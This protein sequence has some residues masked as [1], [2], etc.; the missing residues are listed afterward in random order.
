MCIFFVESNHLSI[1]TDDT[2][3][4][5]T[6]GHVHVKS[7]D[8]LAHPEEPILVIGDFFPFPKTNSLSNFIK[9][10]PCHYSAK[11][12]GFTEGLL[13]LHRK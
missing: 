1:D 8:V 6:F 12:E 7:I 10:L 5:E 2:S 3:I 9:Q 11:K 13:F 4:T